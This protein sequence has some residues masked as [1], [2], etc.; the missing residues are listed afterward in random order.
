[1]TRNKAFA[2]ECTYIE[3]VYVPIDFLCAIIAIV[4]NTDNIIAK[5]IAAIRKIYFGAAGK[6]DSD[7]QELKSL[8]LH[9]V[10][11]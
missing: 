4:M 6:L 11:V 3:L 5:N 8:M 2:L 7:E 9:R 1:M 10:P